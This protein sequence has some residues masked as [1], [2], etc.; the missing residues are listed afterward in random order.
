M[1][2]T[3]QRFYLGVSKLAEFVGRSVEDYIL[4]AAGIANTPCRRAY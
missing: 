1:G 2:C 4:T 3:N